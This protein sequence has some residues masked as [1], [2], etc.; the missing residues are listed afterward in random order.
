MAADLSYYQ[1]PHEVY[2]DDRW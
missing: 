2:I 1:N